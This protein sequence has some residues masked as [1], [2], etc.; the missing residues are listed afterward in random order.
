MNKAEQLVKKL[1]SFS[2]WDIGGSRTQ[3][4]ATLTED[5]VENCVKE[6]YEEVV[7]FKMGSQQHPDFLVAPKR[8]KASIL[9]FADS[10][11]I[12]KGVLEKWET[13][14]H[15]KER[16]RLVRLEVKTGNSNY[17]LNDTFPEPKELLSEIYVLFSLGE[18]KVFVTTSYTIAKNCKCS[19][20]IDKKLEMSKETILCFQ[21]K[22]KSIW[23]GTGIKTAAR[24]TYRMNKDYS[25]INAPISEIATIFKRAGIL[26]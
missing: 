4:T 10:K 6:I 17:T 24:P 20:S 18:R 19:P 5:F 15:N 26:D 7:V 3:G 16:I 2:E 25:H 14:I 23:N 11:K 12:T 8:Y 21:E 1:S 22:L 13:S 9:N